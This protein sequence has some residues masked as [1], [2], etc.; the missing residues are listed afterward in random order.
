MVG[1]LVVVLALAGCGRI[2]FAPTAPSDTRTSDGDGDAG[3][4]SCATAAC[5][6]QSLCASDQ[7]CHPVIFRDDFEDGAIDPAWSLMRFDFAE[8]GGHLQ[9][10]TTTRS[11]FNYGQGGNGRSAVAGVAIGDPTWVDYRVEW[12][13]QSQ[14]SLLFLDGSLPACQ[15]T[16]NIYFRMES[17]EESWNAPQDTVLGFSIDQGCSG[18]IGPAGSWLY[19]GNWHYWIPGTGYST[20]VSGTGYQY[21]GGMSPG[22]TDTPLRF[23]IEVRGTTTK[24]WIDGAIV[25]DE[26]DAAFAYPGGA[27][28]PAYGGVAFSSSWEQMFWIDDVVVA[29]L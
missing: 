21:A 12:T 7:K 25:I 11:G 5:D 1:R 23:A 9:T 20:T 17:Y 4:A 15:H 19:G 6:G 3:L 10:L 27:S 2:E 16:P 24:L 26:D 14:A 22:V 13:Q 18:P 29:P 8:T 28:R